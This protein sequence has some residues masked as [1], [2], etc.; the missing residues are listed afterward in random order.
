MKTKQYIAALFM[1]ILGTTQA[2]AQDWLILAAQD[3]IV[4]YN[5]GGN[6]D[7]PIMRWFW[8]DSVTQSSGQTFYHLPD[9]HAYDAYFYRDTVF[10]S[11]LGDGLIYDVATEQTKIYNLFGDTLTFDLATEVGQEFVVTQDTSGIK[12]YMQVDSVEWQRV[13]GVYDS[14]KYMTIISRL[15]GI[16]TPSYWS[17][18]MCAVSKTQGFIQLPPLYYFP[19]HFEFSPELVVTSSGYNDYIGGMLSRMDSDMVEHIGEYNYFNRKYAPGN[20]FH[21][22]IT[23]DRPGMFTYQTWEDYHHDTIIAVLPN[24]RVVV[25]RGSRSLEGS[26]LTAYSW[27]TDTLNMGYLDTNRYMNFPRLNYEIANEY[28]VQIDTSKPFFLDEIHRIYNYNTTHNDKEAIQ[29]YRII[30]AFEYNEDYHSYFSPDLGKFYS[31][32]YGAA[33]ALQREYT[34]VFNLQ[35]AHIDTLAYGT[36]LEIPDA[37]VDLK[38]S[39]KNLKITPNPAQATI[40]LSDFSKH[41]GS[42]YQILNQL[43][44]T[45]MIGQVEEAHI[46]VHSLAPGLYILVL[47]NGADTYRA[48]VVK[49]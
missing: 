19:Y 21:Y 43:G 29:V 18:K 13:N 9:V 27:H 47:Q 32:Y 10:P 38:T 39:Y 44:Q 3:T 37:V 8:V 42:S 45:V 28:S 22:T 41:L 33:P 5:V 24:D 23:V 30:T 7:T 31:N 12:F 4:S 48:R 40:M 20:I 2:H 15:N 17:G 26:N 1:T 46:Q 25:K 35:Y 49:Q 34:W 16:D 11:K 36:P 14:V 6:I